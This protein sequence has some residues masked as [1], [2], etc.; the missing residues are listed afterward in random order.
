MQLL[1]AIHQ[2]VADACHPRHMCHRLCAIEVLIDVL[3][4]RVVLEST[5]FYII[6]IVGNYVQRKPLQGQCCNILSKLLASF[7]GN[8]SAG[9]VE[10]LGRQLQ[11]VVPKLITA[12]LTNEKE[13]RS[14]T[15]DSSG[16]LSLLRHLTVDADPLLY[17]YIRELEPLPDLDCLK[18]IREFHTS[19]FASYASRDQF[20][21]G[22]LFATG[23]ILVESSY[24]SQQAIVGRYH[25]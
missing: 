21:K 20:L 13:E 7:D 23:T 2:H 18:D 17:D 14:G 10:V 6:C 19:L 12:C 22:S 4:H 24:V 9:T 8:S 11:V 5:C 1:L 3:G 25:R 15:A 16:L